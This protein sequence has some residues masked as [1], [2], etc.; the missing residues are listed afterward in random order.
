MLK[1]RDGHGFLAQILF[2]ILFSF[3]SE[4]RV[5]AQKEIWIQTGF[6]PAQLPFNTEMPE[7]KTPRKKV[8][9]TVELIKGRQ[10][11]AD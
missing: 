9:Q 6:S 11:L 2:T 4:G 1:Q 10:Q 8:A 7:E 5:E 3:Y